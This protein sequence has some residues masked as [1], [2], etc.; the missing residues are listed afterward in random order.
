MIVVL[1]VNLKYYWKANKNHLVLNRSLLKN[2]SC[3]FGCKMAKFKFNNN[4]HP[5]SNAWQNIVPY[6]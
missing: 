1:H 6:W 3:P 5:V 4:K 2:F